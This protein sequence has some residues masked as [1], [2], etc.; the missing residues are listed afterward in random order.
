M[1]KIIDCRLRPPFGSWLKWF[2]ATDMEKALSDLYDIGS[3]SSSI[4]PNNGYTA[5]RSMDLLIDEMD[6]ANIVLAFAESRMIPNADTTNDDIGR[7]QDAYPERFAGFAH[8]MPLEYGIDAA[9]SEIEKY[10][11]HGSAYGI[12]LEPALDHVPYAMDDERMFPIY[13][14]CRDNN[15]PVVFTWGGVLARDHTAYDPAILDHTARMFP[16]MKMM[17]CHAG[18]PY[19]TETIH[20]AYMRKNI[21]LCPEALWMLGF[22]AGTYDYCTAANHMLKDQIVFGTASPGPNLKSVVDAYSNSTLLNKDILP[23]LFYENAATFLG[24]NE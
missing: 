12:A 5:K 14:V 23:K 15:I 6:A 9:L 2:Y 8:V 13:E 17:L 21:Y 19:V 24:L 22:Y 16:S 4:K 1:Y 3:P 11:I 10:V 7:L 18:W 20:V